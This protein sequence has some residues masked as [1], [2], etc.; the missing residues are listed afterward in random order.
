LSTYRYLVFPRGRQPSA[1]EAGELQNYASVLKNRL[2]VGRSRQDGTLVIAF[3]QDVFDQALNTH[4]GFET[5]IR[6]WE[7]RG[8][9]IVD[10]LG[11]VKDA[12]ALRPT[13]S[14]HWAPTEDTLV[15][16]GTPFHKRLAAKELAAQEAIARSWLNVQ[17]TLERHLLLQRIG[18]AVPYALIACG[19]LVVII[20]GFYVSNRM[21]NADRERRSETIE[22]VTEDA[23]EETLEAEHRSPEKKTR[24]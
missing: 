20:T 23:M 9:E 24:D 21:K 1:D 17:Q 11:F 18:K 22:R 19:T 8:C 5:L 14:H 10:K 15:D 13:P 7:R 12:A 16:R 4:A 3:D 2:A 6:N